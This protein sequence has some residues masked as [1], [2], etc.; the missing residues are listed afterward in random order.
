MNSPRIIWDNVKLGEAVLI[1]YPSTAGPYQCLE[2][3]VKWVK[4]KGVP[5]GHC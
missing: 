5:S 4:E 2:G 1:E 3:I